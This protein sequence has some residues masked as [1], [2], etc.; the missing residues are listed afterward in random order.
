M[1]KKKKM[2]TGLPRVRHVEQ[3]CSGLGQGVIR[4]VLKVKG[5]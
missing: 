4:P 3:N 2:L 1:F 5:E